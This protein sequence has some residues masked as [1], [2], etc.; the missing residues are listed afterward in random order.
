MSD[1]FNYFANLSKL[2]F[3]VFRNH[4]YKEFSDE[5]IFTLHLCSCCFSEIS[6]NQSMWVMLGIQGV[7]LGIQGVMAG[8]QIKHNTVLAILIRIQ[9][10]ARGNSR[11]G[12]VIPSQ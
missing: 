10:K 4:I 8:M 9:N 11:V 5:L 7:M 2:P 12:M 1:T 3:L 6:P